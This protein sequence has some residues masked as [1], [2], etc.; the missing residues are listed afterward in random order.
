MESRSEL[1]GYETLHVF[2]EDDG[3]VIITFVDPKI[4]D[5]ARISQIGR[6]MMRVA[7]LEHYPKIIFNFTGVQ[8]MSSAMIAK[9]VLVNKHMRT[10]NGR[11]KLC[12]VAE[13]VMEVFKITQLNMVFDFRNTEEIALRELR[14]N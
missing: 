9:W 1:T 12:C 5:E 11:M 7:N 13:N 6:E 3:V 4:L 8:F 10:T 2:H 14:G